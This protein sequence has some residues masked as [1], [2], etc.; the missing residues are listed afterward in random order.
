MCPITQFEGKALVFN[1]GVVDVKQGDTS[2]VDENKVA[3]IP[4]GNVLIDNET[5][6]KNAN[7]QL[8]IPIDEDTIYID[9]HGFMKAKGGNSE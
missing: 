2:L 5:I 7:N 4:E 1:N 8:E 3:H 9:E 6:I